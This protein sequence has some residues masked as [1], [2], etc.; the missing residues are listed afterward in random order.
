M[1][2][3]EDSPIL[4]LHEVER[5]DRGADEEELHKGVVGRDRSQREK[6]KVPQ[7][8]DD[9]VESLRLEREAWRRPRQKTEGG[10]GD[11]QRQQ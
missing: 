4:E 7:K 6:V 9:D 10:R 11:G 1:G 5:V 3:R 2:D 8:E